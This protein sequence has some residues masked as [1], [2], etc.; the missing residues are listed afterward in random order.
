MGEEKLYPKMRGVDAF[1]AEVSGQKVVCLRDPLNLS[2]KILFLPYPTFFILSLFDGQHSVVDVQTEF[3][4]RFGELLYREKV[5]ELI[6]QLDEHFLLDS[7][8]FQQ[9]ERKMIE[10]F[11]NSPVRPMTLAGES[12]EGDG[13][14][15]KE[16]LASYFTASEGPGLPHAGDESPITPDPPRRSAASPRSPAPAPRSA[17]PGT[18]RP[19]PPW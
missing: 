6:T 9:A 17:C 13:Q 10:S 2:G 5:E 11:K 1:P 14:K 4:R 18:Y 19:R 8:R 7:E 16:T 12:Y 3:M 15:L